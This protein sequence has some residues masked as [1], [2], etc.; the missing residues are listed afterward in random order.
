MTQTFDDESDPYFWSL[1]WCS[2]R[3]FKED[4]A[5]RREVL[6]DLAESAGASLV[7]FK[8]ASKFAIWLVNTPH[9][10]FILVTD[11]REVKPCLQ[12]SELQPV[13][14]QPVFTV[15]LCDSDQKNYE[16]AQ[17]WASSLP[18]RKDPVHVVSSLDFLQ[19]FISTLGYKLESPNVRLFQASSD[20]SDGLL[21][22]YPDGTD[23]TT[24]STPAPA[25]VSCSWARSPSPNNVR[26]K[27]EG[28]DGLT[29]G[30]D[31]AD[32]GAD[33]VKVCISQ[34]AMVKLEA[35]KTI[36]H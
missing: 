16:R 12:V 34:L 36:F 35:E 22:G 28:S 18:P 3:C 13:E 29:G 32:A 19:S 17:L 20:A 33:P 21:Q 30:I 15:V 2:E 8:K 7:S 24:T 4:N 25:S 14:Y 6:E 23:G 5:Q 10:P 26:A 27:S 11:W 31:E 9:K 1:V